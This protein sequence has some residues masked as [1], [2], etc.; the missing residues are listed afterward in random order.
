MKNVKPSAAPQP[1]NF[2]LVISAILILSVLALWIYDGVAKK[3]IFN[4]SNFI[5]YILLSYGIA[6]GSVYLTGYLNIKNAF[7]RA[8]GALGVLAL[9]FIFL[10]RNYDKICLKSTPPKLAYFVT[11]T[12][13]HSDIADTKDKITV[14]VQDY[15][16]NVA[17]AIFDGIGQDT[18]IT[19]SMD[20]ELES[21][22]VNVQV[23]LTTIGSAHDIIML[24]KIEIKGNEEF[25]T[26]DFVRQNGKK[27]GEGRSCKMPVLKDKSLIIEPCDWE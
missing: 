9:C 14:L 2:N 16:S 10:F 22:I 24:D 26:L 4:C 8:G 7:L 25:Y 20:S 15:K 3:E 27:F 12:A 1:H 11:L 18:S 21:P 23:L 19:V 6:S 17:E 13:S 5:L